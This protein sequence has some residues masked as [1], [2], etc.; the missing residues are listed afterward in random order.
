MNF[1]NPNV[2]NYGNTNIYSQTTAPKKVGSTPPRSPHH[3]QRL[4][5]L[6]SK[7]ITYEND[8]NNKIQKKDA[9]NFNNLHDLGPIRLKRHPIYLQQE[10]MGS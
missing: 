10:P 1:K 7:N 4:F 8:G 6:A 5:H 2:I 3:M 9:H